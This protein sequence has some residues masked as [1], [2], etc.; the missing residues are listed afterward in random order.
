MPKTEEILAVAPES[1]ADFIRTHA[2]AR[3]LHVLVKRLNAELLEGDDR[4]RSAA[5]AALRHLGFCDQAAC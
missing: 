4:V 1:V 5:A 3:T 2:A